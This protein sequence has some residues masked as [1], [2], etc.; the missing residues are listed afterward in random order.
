LENERR[1]QNYRLIP[2]SYIDPKNEGLINFD[3]LE[4][5]ICKFYPNI[6]MEDVVCLDIE[7]KLF[8]DLLNN[9][10]THVKFQF[11]ESEIVKMLKLVKTLRPRLKIGIYSLPTRYFYSNSQEKDKTKFDNIL[12]LCDVIFPSLYI[13]YPNDQIG[14]T[15]NLNYIKENLNQAFEYGGRLDKPVLPFM[16]S[17]IH[18]SNV[19]F[20][21]KLLPKNDMD[22][23]IKL[24]SNYSYAGKKVAGIVWW[25]TNEAI[26]KRWYKNYYKELP[27]SGLQDEIFLDY[28]NISK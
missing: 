4:R 3:L 21:Y 9:K 15:K 10:R 17:M 2:Q 19:K 16:W 11:A 27:H 5:T 28:F 25:E 18:P 7:N 14:N 23:Y 6:D 12:K 13:F 26:F 22:E 24:I 1:F 20:S 8:R